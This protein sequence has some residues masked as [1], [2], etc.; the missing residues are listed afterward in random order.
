VILLNDS[1]RKLKIDAYEPCPCGSDKKF[2]FCCYQKAREI[3][4][5]GFKVPEYTEGRMNHEAQE[6][7][8]KSDFKTCLAFDKSECD[9]VIKDAHS[10]QNNRILN[11]ISKDGH[12]YYIKAKLTKKGPE[13]IFDKISRNKASTFFGFCN[14][15]DNELFKPIEQKEY[16]NEPEQN[17]LFAF[18]AHAVEYHRKLRK[19]NHFR[20]MIKINPGL[21]M[22][23]EGVYLYRLHQLDVEDCKKNH[24]TFKRDYFLRDFTKIRT[25]Y[26]KLDF[27][28]SFAACSSFA[29][30]F[31]LEGN[32]IN[33]IYSIREKFIPSIYLNVYPVNNGTNI[34]LSYHLDDEAKYKNYFDQ[35]EMLSN[36]EL[37]NHLNYLIIEY[38]ENVF[39]HPDL[40]ENHLT[41]TQRNS[42]LQSF[43]S[44]ID[45]LK[46]V[47]LI[48]EKNYFNFNL[49][50]PSTT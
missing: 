27:E 10:I 12:V 45:L 20:E 13:A 36:E 26:R 1:S 24:E 21:L 2:K 25:I 7:W 40:I 15:H 11:R 37:I 35:L 3:K 41:K 23:E 30:Q 42:L 32:K 31:D 5:D 22:D 17:F 4:H 34:I 44:S 46:K 14:K 9:D 43:Q 18:R 16:N 50:N 8:K 49:F 6:I 47:D 33:N 39:F 48:Y 38:T 29:V 19:L 28:I